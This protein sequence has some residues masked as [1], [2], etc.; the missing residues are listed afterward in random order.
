MV[1]IFGAIIIIFVSTFSGFELAKKYSN[2]TKNIRQFKF[3]LQ[4][5]SAEIMYGHIPLSVATERIARQVEE[6]LCTF[7][8]IFS[9]KLNEG[10]K[11]VSEAWKES[12]NQIKKDAALQKTEYEVL[13]QF[14]ET[15]GRHDRESQQKHIIL[16][17]NHLEKEEVESKDNQ[18]K[19][20]RMCRS[21]GFLA[22]IL[23]VLLLM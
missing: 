11:Q 1:K 22:G 17:I 3:A 16:A 2:R 23:I 9:S 6:P 13:V 12:L 18:Q 19:Y 21:L 8:N 4:S 5:L 14:G 10:N 7:F 15:L 20:E